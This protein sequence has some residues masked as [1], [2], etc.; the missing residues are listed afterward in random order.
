MALA[1]YHP[2]SL[3]GVYCATLTDTG[4]RRVCLHDRF[5]L[6]LLDTGETLVRCRGED[7]RLK[8]GSVLLLQPGDVQRDLSETPYRAR[9][10]E[11]QT[12]LVR[13]AGGPSAAGPRSAVTHSPALHRASLE[14]IES[15]R[16]QQAIALQQRQAA[17]LLQLLADLVTNAAVRAEPI[18]IAR[19][20]RALSQSPNAN[21]SLD[22]LA[23]RL[24]CAPTYLCA[25]FSEYT[26][27][28]PHAYHL[29]QRLLTARR[30]L[31]RANTV[32]RAAKLTGFTDE[33]HLRRHFIRRFGVSPGRY[34]KAC[35]SGLGEASQHEAPDERRN[36]HGSAMR[37]DD[38]GFAHDRTM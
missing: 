13:A 20:R 27:I 31:E 23:A 36:Q 22:E 32:R 10:L 35:V 21:V 2:S 11:L 8:P 15:V 33:S 34:Q 12:E 18:L 6:Y 30:L 25:V 3:A 16:T 17:R 19:A 5:V 28:G 1:S 37:N 4:T 26:G 24:G 29:Q 9:L 38:M 14:L 7:H